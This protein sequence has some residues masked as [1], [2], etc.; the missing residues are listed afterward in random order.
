[1]K[2]LWLG[3][4]VVAGILFGVPAYGDVYHYACKRGDDRYAVN[5]NTDRGIL[6]MLEHGPP[7]NVTTFRILKDTPACGRGGWKLSDDATFC[8]YTR[9]VADLDWHGR[10]FD[11]DQADAANN[12][13]TIQ[14]GVGIGWVKSTDIRCDQ[15]NTCFL[16]NNYAE[17]GCAN[18]GIP[19]Y[20]RPSGNPIGELASEV[21]AG[22]EG[23]VPGENKQGYTFVSYRADNK[24]PPSLLPFNMQDLH[25]CV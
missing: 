1:M 20:S 11:C 6:T 4:A 16:K 18:Y 12:I 22:L 5:V 19:V 9:G 24:D 10:Q 14:P 23:V 2:K 3:F 15:N 7:H 25:A 21:V 17:N 13:E 8:Y